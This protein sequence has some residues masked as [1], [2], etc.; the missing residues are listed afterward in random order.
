VNTRVLLVE[1]SPG[2]ALV[3][4][5]VLEP[6]ADVVTVGTATAARIAFV[7]YRWDL[8]ILDLFLDQSESGLDVLKVIKE[9]RPDQ[10]VVV[11]SHAVTDMI[12]RQCVELGAD[13][14]LDKA[15]GSDQLLRFLPDGS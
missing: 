10:R 3:T 5:I 4:R 2:Q 13:A 8:V 6:Y 12:R 9:V 11:H 15:E 7:K 14:V 1:D